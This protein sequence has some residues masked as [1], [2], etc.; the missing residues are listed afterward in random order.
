MAKFK[1]KCK[2]KLDNGDPCD[3]YVTTKMHKGL[4]TVVQI[5]RLNKEIDIMRTEELDVT[6]LV[7]KRNI[8]KSVPE[9]PKDWEFTLICVRDHEDDYSYDE[10]I[11]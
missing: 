5:Q 10:R 4:S 3:K 7:K 8:L 1:F 9:V 11:K 6:E 2:G